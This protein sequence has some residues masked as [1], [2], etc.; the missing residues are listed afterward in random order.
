MTNCPGGHEIVQSA[1]AEH[2]LS[3][4][5]FP[6]AHAWQMVAPDLEYLPDGQE[7]QIAG[8]AGVSIEVPARYVQLGHG[9]Q[10]ELIFELIFPAGHATHGIVSMRVASYTNPEGHCTH[11]TASISQNI[12]S[13]I[14][15]C[16]GMTNKCS[17][18]FIFIIV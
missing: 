1:A 2:F 6:A 8:H 11:V 4:V 17:V 16:D 10:N 14:S 9:L 18:R 15:S 7:T 12:F 13:F 3:S 5:D